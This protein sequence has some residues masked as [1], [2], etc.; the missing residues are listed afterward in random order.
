[1]G[2]E[3]AGGTHSRGC[4]ALGQLDGDNENVLNERVHPQGRKV[5]QGPGHVGQVWVSKSVWVF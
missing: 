2:P 1:M 3:P 5:S 4:R